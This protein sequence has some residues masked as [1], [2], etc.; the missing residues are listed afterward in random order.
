VFT[1]SLPR[2]SVKVAVA[3]GT[4]LPSRCL[5]VRPFGGYWLVLLGA[6]AP[7]TCLTSLCHGNVFTKPLLCKPIIERWRCCLSVCLFVCLSGSR[8]PGN[9]LA[10]L[11]PREHVS[12]SPFYTPIKLT[13]NGAP[14]SF[15]KFHGNRRVILTRYQSHSKVLYVRWIL[16]NVF[17][18]FLMAKTDD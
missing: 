2:E 16:Q 10:E 8:C 18:Y 13:E 17:I 15:T 1:E 9:M 3:T 6:V 11:F 7:E 4:C 14:D 5:F 12:L